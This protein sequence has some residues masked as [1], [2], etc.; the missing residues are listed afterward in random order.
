MAI[1]LFCWSS[2]SCSVSEDLL[3][4]ATS[5]AKLRCYTRTSLTR[6]TYG[7]LV[8][9]LKLACRRFLLLSTQSQGG[10]ELRIHSCMEARSTQSHLEDE[11][12]VDNQQSNENDQIICKVDKKVSF[13]WH[14]PQ[15]VLSFE[16][17]WVESQSNYPKLHGEFLLKILQKDIGRTLT[18]IDTHTASS[19]RIE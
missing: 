1:S 7:T 5:W 9:A 19:I 14:N 10:H 18:Y 17:K 15:L 2:T 8:V 3:C 11:T 16:I 13:K 4:E 12:A 6:T